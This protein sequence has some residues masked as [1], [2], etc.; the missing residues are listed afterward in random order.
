VVLLAEPFGNVLVASRR[1]VLG[2]PGATVL[3]RRPGT[4]LPLALAALLL[5]GLTSA[6]FA[7]SD[8]VVSIVDGDTLV[9]KATGTVRLIGID[10]PE[11]VDPR[12]PVQAFGAEASAALRQMVGSQQVRLTFEDQRKDK[13]GRTLAYVYLADGTF[14]NLEMVRR[15]YAHAY[16]DYPFQHMAQF[17]AAEREAREA[18]RGL[19]AGGHSATTPRGFVGSPGAG[20]SGPTATQVWVNTSSRVYHCPGTRYFGKTAR[21]QY[22]TEADAHARG[23]RPAYGSACGPVEDDAPMPAASTAPRAVAGSSS[24]ATRE[25]GADIQVWVNTSSRV[26]HCP[27]TRYYGQTKSGQYMRQSDARAAGHR[28]AGGRDCR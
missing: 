2:L 1:V 15:G 23:H 25:P 7:Q 4:S 27:G 9:L 16:L 3:G 19:W 21:G 26:Y 6:A 22:M 11:T 12:V 28:P 8:T 5:A 17:R 10:T 20:L 14:V 18:R 13:Y 24:S